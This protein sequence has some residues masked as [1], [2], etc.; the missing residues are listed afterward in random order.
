VAR[1]GDDLTIVSAGKAWRT[2]W[3]PAEEL[4]AD[5]IRPRSSTCARCDRSTSAAFWSRWRGRTACWPSRRSPHRRVGRRPARRWWPSRAARSRRRLD[6]RHR[7]DADPYSPTLEDAYIPDTAAIVASVRSRAGGRRDL[8]AV[9]V[10]SVPLAR[11]RRRD[12]TRHRSPA[13]ARARGRRDL[14]AAEGRNA[15]GRLKR[16]WGRPPACSCRSLPSTDAWTDSGRGPPPSARAALAWFVLFVPRRTWATADLGSLLSTA[17]ACTGADSERGLKLLRSQFYY[18]VSCFTLVVRPTAPRFDRGGRGGRPAGGGPAGQ[19]RRRA[20]SCGPRPRRLRPRS[21]TSLE[22]PSHRT[23][24]PDVRRAIA[25]SPARGCTERVPALPRRAA[26]LQPGPDHGESIAI[27][28]ALVVLAIVSWA[29][30]RNAPSAVSSIT[31]A[32]MRVIK[33]D[34]GDLGD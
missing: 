30:L 14:T 2:C 10:A 26:A 27:P 16:P 5:G 11:R 8:T 15:H 29:R 18:V 25:G 32:E 21:T 28:V 4:A 9:I 19:W 7:R 1:D 3:P 13:S 20:R 22:N 31:W 6:L 34:L 33:C 17:S 12:L 24:T 23:A